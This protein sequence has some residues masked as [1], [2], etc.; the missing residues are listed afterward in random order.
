[1][2]DARNL[3]VEAVGVMRARGKPGQGAGC[4]D[5]AYREISLAA[6]MGARFSESRNG[7]LAEI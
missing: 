1:M 5:D 7:A 2:R 6:T 3:P 4:S